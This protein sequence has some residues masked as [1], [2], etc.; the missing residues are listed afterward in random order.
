LKHVCGGR[1]IQLNLAGDNPQKVVRRKAV[2]SNLGT[3]ED[4]IHDIAKVPVT[5]HHWSYAQ[6]EYFENNHH[7]GT[8]IALATMK[9]IADPL[10]KEDRIKK[11]NEWLYFHTP[12]HP[13][14]KVKTA[15]F[16]SQG[17]ADHSIA[18]QVLREH[19]IAAMEAAKEQQRND[20]IAK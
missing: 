1:A 20:N 17:R 6:L 3:S 5:R 10:N 16:G 14:D 8:P 7:V 9:E 19:E 12:N 2:L 11:G 4:N 13:Y 18:R 15:A